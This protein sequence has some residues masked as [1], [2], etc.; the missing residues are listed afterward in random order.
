MFFPCTSLPV[1]QLRAGRN[2]SYPCVMSDTQG[3]VNLK[4][5]SH[6][7][8]QVLGCRTPLHT[9]TLTVQDGPPTLK[10]V[11]NFLLI[12]MTPPNYAA[13]K[14]KRGGSYPA[15]FTPRTPMARGISMEL[16][17]LHLLLCALNPYGLWTMSHSGFC[18][19][20]HSH[21]TRV[22]TLCLVRV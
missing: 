11:V 20:R 3:A 4:T 8:S 17:S 7:F 22:L 12:F 6:L 10:T 18:R 5:T 1:R 16:T 19:D 2:V 13:Q 14:M 15:R 9:L 21:L